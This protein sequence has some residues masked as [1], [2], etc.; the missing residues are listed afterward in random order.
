MVI[1]QNKGH[2]Q[3]GPV[4]RAVA[5][6]AKMF[7][8]TPTEAVY[9]DSVRADRLAYQQYFPSLLDNVVPVPNSSPLE[10]FRVPGSWRTVHLTSTTQVNLRFDNIMAIHDDS[11]PVVVGVSMCWPVDVTS[12]V[13]GR[14]A[15]IQIAHESTVYLIQVSSSS[16]S[17]NRLRAESHDIF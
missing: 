2:E 15:L 9:T 17:K 3:I 10:P 1:T 13:H 16:C 6:A 11:H 4:L 12:G 8:H 5:A 7:G 14:V